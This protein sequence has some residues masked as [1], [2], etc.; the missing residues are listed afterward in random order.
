MSHSLSFLGR[1]RGTR[2]TSSPVHAEGRPKLVRPN[3][4][5]SF[6]GRRLV[7]GKSGA[8]Q[9][10]ESWKNLR[11]TTYPGPRTCSLSKTAQLHIPIFTSGPCLESFFNLLKP[12][13]PEPSHVWPLSLSLCQVELDHDLGSAIVHE[14]NLQ[15]LRDL[16]GPVDQRT[17]DGEAPAGAEQPQAVQKPQGSPRRCWS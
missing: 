3:F 10:E 13:H 7:I 17:K 9:P 8:V 11:N 4:V 1:A 6:Q 14:S 12:K 16:E 5:L 15:L 2:R